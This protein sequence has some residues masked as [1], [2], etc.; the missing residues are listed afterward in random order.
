MR[1]G[2]PF[3]AP[4]VRWDVEKVAP[5]ADAEHPLAQLRDAVVG[6]EQDPIF[7]CV[8]GGASPNQE[9]IEHRAVL[10]AIG[11]AVY[12][13]H[14]ECLR[15]DALEQADVVVQQA[16]LRIRPRSLVLEP[17]AALG[18]R[19]ARRAAYQQAS[20]PALDPSALKQFVRGY[21]Q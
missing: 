2:W 21:G 8:S 7:D 6:G 19:R 13:L 15:L 17:V 11:E 20:L 1:C 4:E 14:H 12:V 10:V 5:D 9:A 3:E 18:E 16:G